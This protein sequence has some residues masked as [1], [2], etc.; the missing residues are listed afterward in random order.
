MID[1]EGVI[2]EFVCD[3][4]DGEGFWSEPEREFAFVVFDEDS[5]E[6]LEGAE[7]G[8]MEHDGGM[9]LSVCADVVSSESFWEYEVCLEGS[10]LPFSGEGITED[11]IEF[12]SVEGA[13][14][15]V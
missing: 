14:S 15:W 1:F 7:Y 2:I 6:S 5:D 8:A 11:E 10:A 4:G 3:G 13:F 9:F 12:G